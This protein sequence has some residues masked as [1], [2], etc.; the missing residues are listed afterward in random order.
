VVIKKYG[1]D[2]FI[3]DGFQMVQVI[4][5]SDAQSKSVTNSQ[6]GRGFPKYGNAVN[7]IN[8]KI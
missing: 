8:D 6:F 3:V 1:M 2:H 4:R 7:L 5:V